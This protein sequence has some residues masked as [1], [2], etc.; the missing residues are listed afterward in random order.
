MP[1]EFSRAQ[2]FGDQLQRELAILIRDYLKDPRIGMVTLSGTRL[3]KDM[4]H[5]TIYLTVMESE[6]AKETLEALNHAEGRLRGELGRLLHVRTI[7]HL[8]FV[9]D[10]SQ[11]RGARIDALLN[12]LKPDTAEH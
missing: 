12:G 11:E 7:P 10:E 6:R 9:Y 1:R 2:R 5:A 8:R 4:R 3:S